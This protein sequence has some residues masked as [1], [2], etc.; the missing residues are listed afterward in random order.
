MNSEL[1]NRLTIR[2]LAISLSTV[3]LQAAACGG[4]PESAVP[5]GAKEEVGAEG[6]DVV[7]LDS[8]AIAIANIVVEPVGLTETTGLPVTGTIT[9][10]AN[11]V[12]HIGPRTNGRIVQLAAD[13]GD[14]VTGGQT[15]AILE[16]PEVGQ[17][18]ADESE[19]AALVDIARENY[20]REERLEQQGISSRKELLDA[21][22]ELRRMEASDERTRAASGS[23]SGR[24]RGRSVRPDVTVCGRRR[25]PRRKPRRDGES[26]R[27]DFH[28]CKP[29]A[30]LD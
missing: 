3:L 19:A 23:R 16:S 10:D 8:S 13:V 11:R 18:R 2:T 28:R 22:A 15:M 25:G 26:C 4:D 21:E 30:A 5:E 17:V 7:Q 6:H 14:A 9:Y 12:S 20:E 27:S 1:M 29:R 24:R